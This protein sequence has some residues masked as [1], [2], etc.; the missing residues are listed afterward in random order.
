MRIVLANLTSAGL[1]LTALALVWWL[2]RNLEEQAGFAVRQGNPVAIQITMAAAQAPAEEVPVEVEADSPPTEAPPPVSDTSPL[3]PASS[4]VATETPLA[5]E[6]LPAMEVEA[7]SELSQEAIASTTSAPTLPELRPSEAKPVTQPDPA[8]LPTE[9]KP[10]SRQVQRQPSI[11]IPFQ[12]ET[13]AGV[14]LESP[15]STL[16]AN[17]PPTYPTDALLAR[18]E[19]R[20]ILRVQVKATG[21]AQQVLLENSSGHPALDEAARLAV[22]K[23]KFRPAKR[24]GKPIESE[25]LVPINFSIRRS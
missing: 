25:V 21:E 9:A 23:W 5:R 1:H 22:I 15:A 3:A 24:A 14:S 7:P 10:L 2:E 11:A 4:E 19:G 13:L 6:P 20:V 8:K 17:I 16:P 12:V 18:L